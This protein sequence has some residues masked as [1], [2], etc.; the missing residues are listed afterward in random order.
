RSERKKA[1]D[2]ALELFGLTP[3]PDRRV[4]RLSMGERQRV[5]LAMG[6][7]H[8]PPVVLLDEPWNSL[9]EAGM[10]I[11]RHAITSCRHQGGTIVCVSPTG[12]TLE[13]LADERYE[14]GGGKVT[15]R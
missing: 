12:E 11:V 13:E 9:D 2:R 1:I 8:S 4:D 3:F 6:F 10:D 14:V 5:R 7:L 15:A